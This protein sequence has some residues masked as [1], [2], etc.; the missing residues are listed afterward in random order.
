REVAVLERELLARGR[1]GTARG[2]NAIDACRLRGDFDSREGIIRGAALLLQIRRIDDDVICDFLHS[3]AKSFHSA[4]TEHWMVERSRPQERRQ[5]RNAAMSH[6][7]M[8]RL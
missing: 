5:A 1:Q 3:T 6:G 8:N 2:Q 7:A 4:P